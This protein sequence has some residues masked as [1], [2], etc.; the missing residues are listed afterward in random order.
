VPAAVQTLKPLCVHH[1]EMQLQ[2]HLARAA[3]RRLPAK[4]VCTSA[5][6]AAAVVAIL[7]ALPALLAAVAVS[8]RGLAPSCLLLA[9][10]LLAA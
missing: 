7:V 3:L 4:W 1:L 5:L 9:A 6:V 2:I 8:Q 10:A